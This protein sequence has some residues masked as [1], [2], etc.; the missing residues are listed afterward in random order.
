MK[1]LFITIIV[2]LLS[3][4]YE[5]PKLYFV[6]DTGRFIVYEERAIDMK[7]TTI[8]LEDCD[9]GTLYDIQPHSEVFMARGVLW[10]RY[11]KLIPK[12]SVHIYIAYED[13]LKKYGVCTVL[14]K[15]MFVKT[16]NITYEDAK[17]IN[18]RIVFD[19]K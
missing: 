5:N 11:S 6:N 4:C 18:W 13:T 9:R 12:K 14:E 8:S 15:R 3:S 16:Y 10:R 1:K 17:R 19:G 7:D 2:I